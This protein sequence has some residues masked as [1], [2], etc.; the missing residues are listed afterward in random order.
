MEIEQ[1]ENKQCPYCNAILDINVQKCK[2]CGEWIIKTNN[3]TMF[4]L[5][6][7]LLSI[8][9]SLIIT[10]SLGYFILDFYN[11]PLYPFVVISYTIHPLCRY[12]FD[13]KKMSEKHSL[14][15]RLLLSFVIM[16]I[17]RMIAF[18]GNKIN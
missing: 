6:S 13:Y 15:R 9:I 3:E 10:I 7:F 1:S 18:Y 11:N 5:W 4:P 8:F 17:L 2:Y 12:K 16:H 14:L